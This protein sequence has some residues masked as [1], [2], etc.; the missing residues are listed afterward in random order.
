MSS[1]FRLGKHK[2]GAPAHPDVA[3][4]APADGQVLTY[5]GADAKWEN[6]APTGGGAGKA[7][8]GF[9]EIEGAYDALNG[10][11]WG[12]NDGYVNYVD[13]TIVQTPIPAGTFKKLK[14]HIYLYTLNAG[15]YLTLRVNGQNSA[16]RIYLYGTGTFVLAADVSVSENDLV[17]FRFETPATSGYIMFSA[18]LEFVAT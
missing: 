12:L 18:G 2:L 8:F 11:V 5:V 6:K 9:R 14:V 13:D 15:A 1:G 4:S 16:L 10:R 3:I 17:N 7:Y